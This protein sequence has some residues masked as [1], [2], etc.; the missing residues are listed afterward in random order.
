MKVGIVA[1]EFLDAE[2]GRVGGFG[3]AA[4]EAARV[5]SERGDEIVYFSGELHEDQVGREA[6]VHGHPLV[7]VRK[8]RLA[9]L[10]ALRRAKP[11]VLLTVDFRPNYLPVLRALRDVT[12]IVWI[13]DPR[14]PEDTARLAQLRLPD[15]S[16]PDVGVLAPDCTALGPLVRRRG[17]NRIRLASVDPGVFAPRAAG[18]YDVAGLDIAMLPN[19]I[20]LDAAPRAEA[21][22]PTVLFLG[23]LDPYKRPWVAFEIARRMPDVQFRFLG[24]PHFDPPDPA[25]VPPN[26]SLEGHLDGAA[27]AAAIAS[28]WALLNTSLHEGIPVTFYEAMA[29]GLPI[30]SGLDPGGTVTRAGIAVGAPEGDGLDAVPRYVEALT[31]LLGDEQLRRARGEAG[32][33]WV[34]EHHGPD[35]F[36]AAFDRLA[37]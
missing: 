3:W 30:V 29:S 4:R 9:H 25:T 19:P 36:L 5:L 10:T 26:A 11:E 12:T 34:N 18:A 8:R 7:P 17:P 1:N 20:R 32:R 33:A 37:A 13:R 16:T 24:K 21:S 6:E 14:G 27:K 23:R 31:T 2:R 22:T 15:G 28:S 35:A